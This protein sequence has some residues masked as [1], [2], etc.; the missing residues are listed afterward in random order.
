ML[1]SSRNLSDENDKNSFPG[2]DEKGRRG[3]EG[4]GEGYIGYSCLKG[5]YRFQT[6]N[7]LICSL[8]KRKGVMNGISYQ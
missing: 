6:I 1:K 2:G 4:D 3:K 8:S 5:K 7:F